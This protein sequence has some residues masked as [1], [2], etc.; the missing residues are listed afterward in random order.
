M[1]VGDPRGHKPWVGWGGVGWDESEDT[2]A[3]DMT[4]FCAA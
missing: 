3:F 4:A 2:A 1:Q